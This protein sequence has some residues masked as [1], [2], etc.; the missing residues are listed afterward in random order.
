MPFFGGQTREFFRVLGRCRIA[1]IA[2]D[3]VEISQDGRDE[4]GVS[5]LARQVQRLAG[6]RERS[7][8]VPELEG[9]FAEGRMKPSRQRATREGGAPG[10][11]LRLPPGLLVV[12]PLHQ[13][14]DPDQTIGRQGPA[15]QALEDA[16]EVHHDLRATSSIPATSRRV[17]SLADSPRNMLANSPSRSSSASGAICVVVRPFAFVLR[18]DQWC[19]A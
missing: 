4:V 3:L 5:R 17:V 6:R 19:R 9:A 18:I 10:E 14:F 8:G 11:L 7:G 16:D 13:R 12:A 2:M 1:E 15:Q